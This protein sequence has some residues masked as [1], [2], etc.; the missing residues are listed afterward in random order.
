MI[1][2][3]LGCCGSS[4]STVEGAES[5]PFDSIACFQTLALRSLTVTPAWRKVHKSVT[6][7]SSRITPPLLSASSSSGS[8][9]QDEAGQSTKLEGGPVRETKYE[10]IRG[11]ETVRE[12]EVAL[13]KPRSRA[14]P[15]IYPQPSS[16]NRS[17]HYHTRTH[18]RS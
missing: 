5:S 13:D 1:T 8:S 15:V 6:W 14:E 2:L 12:R 7:V 4:G 18:T 10:G 9:F 16:D 3:F 17:S 11:G